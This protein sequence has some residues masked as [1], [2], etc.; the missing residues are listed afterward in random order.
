MPVPPAP[1][2]ATFHCRR[3]GTCCRWPG[4]VILEPGDPD[5]IVA[6]LG[7]PVETFLRD[8][9]ALA[10]NRAALTIIDAPGTT[11]CLFL[12]PDN[13]CRIYPVRPRQCRTFPFAWRV[14]GCPALGDTP[15]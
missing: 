6:H 5:R 15:S 12:S 3:C 4:S 1:D 2:P 13:T 8:C 9:T 7:I 11:A 14:P 10:R